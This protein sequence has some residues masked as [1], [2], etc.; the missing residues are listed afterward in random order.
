MPNRKIS[1]CRKTASLNNC[2]VTIAGTEEEVVPLA[3]HHAVA[4]HGHRDS[5]ELWADI[6]A[7]LE[8]EKQ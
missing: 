3:V 1:D 5:P 8:D 4:H 7:R 6:R 2:S